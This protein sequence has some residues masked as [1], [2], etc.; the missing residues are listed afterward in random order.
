M[1]HT[2]TTTFPTGGDS[3][4]LTLDQLEMMN[5]MNGESPLLAEL[6]DIETAWRD[7]QK[8]LTAER[9][10]W[11]NDTVYEHIR[12]HVTGTSATIRDMLVGAALL[13]DRSVEMTASVFSYN[14]VVFHQG[15]DR[16]ASVPPRWEH[17]VCEQYEQV[18]VH[19]VFQDTDILMRLS[20][21]FGSK[22]EVSTLLSP[23]AGAVTKDFTP[24]RC[25]VN[26]TF[27]PEGVHPGLLR[28]MLAVHDRYSD[29]LPHPCGRIVTGPQPEDEEDDEGERY[30]RGH[31]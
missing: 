25:Y 5:T 6:G 3:I 10:Q 29:Y 2:T 22:F 31:D 7:R 27:H 24:M 26:L 8:E 21:M 16:T 19:Q 14:T 12:K 1:E 4:T 30:Y 13:A 11:A 18:R 9:L 20:A 15:K 17:V 28:E 23:I